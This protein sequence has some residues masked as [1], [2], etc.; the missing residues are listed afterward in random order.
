[1]KVANLLLATAA[2]VPATC[3]TIPSVRDAIT[4]RVVAARGTTIIH[5]DRSKVESGWNEHKEKP[6]RI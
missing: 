1:M 4:T 6:A 2:V 3:G 5:P